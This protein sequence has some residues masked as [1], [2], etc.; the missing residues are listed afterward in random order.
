MA[1]LRYN[2]FSL[3][4][5]AKLAALIFR[6]D[7]S[8]P[9]LALAKREYEHV[10]VR[11][12]A[13]FT[14]L[15]GEKQNL[16]IAQT[17]L[18][19]AKR[20]HE[21]AVLDHRLFLRDFRPYT[22]KGA[23]RIAF[24]RTS[25]IKKKEAARMQQ[26]TDRIEAQAQVVK[27]RKAAVKKIEASVAQL[28]RD[29]DAVD[30]DRFRLEDDIIR[31]TLAAVTRHWTAGEPREALSVVEATLDF[32]KANRTLF[33]VRFLAYVFAG[34]FHEA[35]K[36]RLAFTSLYKNQATDDAMFL[37]ADA[38]RN[39]ESEAHVSIYHDTDFDDA[40]IHLMYQIIRLWRRYPVDA[41]N[42]A[43]ARVLAA[44]KLLE[45]IRR[46]RPDE[47]D[48]VMREAGADSEFAWELTAFINLRHGNVSRAA[49][50]LGINPDWKPKNPTEAPPPPPAGAHHALLS[51]LAARPMNAELARRWL[52]MIP[53]AEG[54]NMYW[55]VLAVVKGGAAY[56]E[57]AR[58]DFTQEYHINV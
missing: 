53:R 37:V 20:E 58:N 6:V 16:R 42:V 11:H 39:P 46:D 26:F 17:R 23:E 50:A 35:D 3:P 44:L 34:E 41:A 52:E 2:W 13:C 18:D 8:T 4:S 51:V 36:A 49:E 28:Q 24:W 54:D 14:N 22:P 40:R 25:A 19:D 27:D 7:E 31:A 10:R 43:D 12:T 1:E 45:A 30:A 21:K 48:A 33:F 38:V 47:A 57:H 55:Y 9:D 32:L 5:F 29:F 15:Q 56:L